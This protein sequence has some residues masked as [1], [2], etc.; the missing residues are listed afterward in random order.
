MKNIVKTRIVKND[1]NQKL[2]GSLKS[3]FFDDI[4]I[5]SG[6][7]SNEVHMV[8]G[9]KIASFLVFYSDS[10]VALANVPV[11]GTLCNM[12]MQYLSLD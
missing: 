10:T 6:V 12:Y 9:T 7:V 8:N 1:C 5:D 4:S 11:G 3:E 2:V